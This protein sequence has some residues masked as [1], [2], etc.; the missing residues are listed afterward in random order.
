MAANLA[1]AA[2]ARPAPAPAL[3][4]G[5]LPVLE[6]DAA[7][8]EA[9][10]PVELPRDPAPRGNGGAHARTTGARLAAQP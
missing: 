2:P 8:F 6:L 9:P 1:P 4:L 10:A 7:A 3:D 5:A